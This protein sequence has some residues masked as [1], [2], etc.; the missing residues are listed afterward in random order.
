MEEEVKDP[1]SSTGDDFFGELK[2]YKPE[3]VKDDGDFKPLKG[4]YITVVKK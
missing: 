3:E 1:F 4:S 2:D